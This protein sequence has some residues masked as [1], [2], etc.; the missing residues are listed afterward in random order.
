[1]FLYSQL[2][3]I[4]NYSKVNLCDD[5]CYVQGTVEQHNEKEYEMPVP[6]KKYKEVQMME[7][8]VAICLILCCYRVTMLKQTF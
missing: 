2:E 3:N 1:M 4:Y 5:P 6:R 7:N 8:G